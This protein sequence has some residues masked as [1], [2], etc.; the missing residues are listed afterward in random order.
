MPLLN[1]LD[2]QFHWVV[3]SNAL[4]VRLPQKEQSFALFLASDNIR[5]SGFEIAMSKEFRLL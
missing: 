5:E 1:R 2:C 4:T 3:D